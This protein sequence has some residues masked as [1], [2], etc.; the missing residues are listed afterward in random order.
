MKNKILLILVTA[1]VLSLV[2]VLNSHQIRPQRNTSFRPVPLQSNQSLVYSSQ[3]KLLAENTSN[4]TSLLFQGNNA[5]KSSRGIMVKTTG[6][7]SRFTIA[8]D[9]AFPHVLNTLKDV[10]KIAS[11]RWV[12][13]LASIM[14]K[15]PMNRT[16]IVVSG[17]TEFQQPLLNW[18]VSAVFKANISLDRILIL[19]ADEML[20]NLLQER[21]IGSIFVPPTSLYAS[22][23]ITLSTHR[24][25]T[26]SRFAVVR[27]LNHWGFTVAHY[28]SDALILRDTQQIFENYPLSS[29]VASRGA[30]RRT[31]CAGAI[32]F[33][34]NRLMGK[35]H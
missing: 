29:I 20:Y 33:R 30:G 27:L 14:A 4:K 6:G 10:K 26:Y 11:T 1:V 24:L 16:V 8:N 28:D 34:S 9:F 18:M 13:V 12:Q 15:W 5:E 23:S 19:A 35:S 17:N 7:A 21:S 3:R 31:L 2:Y 32:L 25:I 22:K